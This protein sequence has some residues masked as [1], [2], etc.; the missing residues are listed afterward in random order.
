MTSSL[1]GDLHDRSG[2]LNTAGRFLVLLCNP[3]IQIDDW[4]TPSQILRRSS[5][6]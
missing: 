3:D 6:K 1:V 4:A 2:A 5:V